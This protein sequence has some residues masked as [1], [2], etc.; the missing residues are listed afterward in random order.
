MP[1]SL[2][3]PAAAGRGLGLGRP[4]ARREVPAGE[5]RRTAEPEREEDQD[6]QQQ[7]AD[8]PQIPE[9]QAG[10][11]Q[12]VAALTGLADPPPGRVPEEDRHQA[13]RQREA[14]LAD[15]ADQ[16]RDRE[17]ARALLHHYRRG[18]RS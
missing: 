1:S 5:R 3:R 6:D 2:S 10:D 16:G 18:R 17:S 11:S 12:A 15:S 7:A 9:D 8:E 13:D 4:A 14:E